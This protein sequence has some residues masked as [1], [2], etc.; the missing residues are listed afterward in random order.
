[1]EWAQRGRLFEPPSH[2]EWMSSHAA[3]PIPVERERGEYRVYFSGRDAAQRSSI[4]FFE[5]QLEPDVAV[6]RVSSSAVLGPGELGAFD[7]SGVTGACA[8]RVGGA[9]YLY[10]TGW[11]LGVTVP[12]YFGIGLAVSDDGERFE[13]V[14]RAPVLGRTATDPFLVASPSILVEEGLWRMWYV[15]GLEWT[16]EPDARGAPR[17]HYHIRYA[18]SDDGIEWRPTGRVCIDF[19]GPQE[20]AFGRPWVVKHGGL[21]RMWYA[22]R[23]ESYRIGYAESR[24]GLEWER[25]DGQAGIAASGAGWDAQMVEYPAVFGPPGRLAMLYNGDGYGATGIGLALGVG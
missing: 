25:L 13:R 8:V 15:S 3:L 4:G 24:N 11:S 16:R 7:D 9:L 2:L 10:Y 22:V 23:G 18:E 6:G 19:A 1:M 17:H 14:S 20:Y 21:Y 5:L 12:F